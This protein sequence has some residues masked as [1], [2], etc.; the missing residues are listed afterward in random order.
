[1]HGGWMHIIMNMFML[2]MFGMVIENV[3]GPKKFFI[4]LSAALVP[5]GG[6]EL[7]QYGSY[8]I[9]GLDAYQYVSMGGQPMLWTITSI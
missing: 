5:P 9:N 6:Q 8:I 1:M 7:A 4:T 2:W 3:W